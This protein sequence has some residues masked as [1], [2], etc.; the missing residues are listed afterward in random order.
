MEKLSASIK[1]D[2]ARIN[3]PIGNEKYLKLNQLLD[4]RHAY[5]PKQFFDPATGQMVTDPGNPE[6]VKRIDEAIMN[7][8]GMVYGVE[9]PVVIQPKIGGQIR[10]PFGNL[11]IYAGGGGAPVPSGGNQ[12]DRVVEAMGGTERGPTA[13]GEGLRRIWYGKD[14]QTDVRQTPEFKQ[15]VRALMK[16]RG[17]NKQ[18]AETELMRVIQEQANAQ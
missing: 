8:L 16:K 14:Y 18:E 6:M 15:R 2:E 1:A 5:Q 9:D 10:S 11:N 13:M 3:A 7:V 4:G 12:V 17:L